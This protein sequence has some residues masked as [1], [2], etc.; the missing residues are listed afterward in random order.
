L[1][2]VVGVLAVGALVLGTGVASAQTEPSLTW[3]PCQEDTTVECSTLSLPVDWAK[4]NSDKFDLAVDRLKATDPAHRIGVLFINPGGPGGSGVNFVISDVR[5]WFS[6]DILARFDI[7]GFDPRGVANSQPVKCSLDMIE[8]APSLYPTNQAEFDTMARFARDLHDDCRKQSGPIVDHADSVSVARD[9]D[10]LRQALG[11]QKINYYGVSYGTLM[12]QMY[13]EQFGDHVRAM[14]IDSN[15]D[16]SLSTIPFVTKS[17]RGVE[18]SFNEFVK[19]CGRTTSCPLHGKDI[20]ALWDKLMD[21]ADRGELTDP[22]DPSVRLSSLDLVGGA[23]NMF[24]GPGWAR[25]ATLISQLAAKTP[26]PR[27]FADDLA[28]ES[29]FRAV[30]CGDYGVQVATYDDYK[31]TNAVEN[32]VSPHMRGGILGH[33]AY[34]ACVGWTDHPA[35]PQHRL[36]LRNA[37][38]ILMLNAKHDPATSYAWA[39]GVH[40]QTMDKTVLVTYD[41]WGHATYPRTECTH[42]VVDNYLIS[43]TVPKD[44][45]HCAAVEPSS[46]SARAAT[47]SRRVIVP[48]W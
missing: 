47:P 15:M 36:N 18:D 22:D 29:P 45:T 35:N 8:R 24:Y 25:L 48:R 7:I 27:A 30:L 44:G 39:S 12:G 43:G 42:A 21:R 34:A 1:R 41:G 38:K 19:W 10:A 16:H 14:T 13:A 32:A 33:R 11:E 46:E 9:M 31:L 6:P 40:R 28:V 23:S 37:P 3:K 17:A 20:P 26:A 5:T 2:T 4:P